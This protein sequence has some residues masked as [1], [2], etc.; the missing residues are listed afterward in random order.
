MWESGVGRPPWVLSSPFPP[1]HR[2]LPVVGGSSA[3]GKRAA[4]PRG[5]SSDMSTRGGGHLEKGR[6]RSR[7]RRRRRRSNR[8]HP[9]E[10]RV[11]EAGGSIPVLGRTNGMVAVG[12]WAARYEI[13][14][15][16]SA[17]CSSAELV[18]AIHKGEEGTEDILYEGRLLNFPPVERKSSRSERGSTGESRQSAAERDGKEPLL[19]SDEEDKKSE[20]VSAK[21]LEMEP[22]APG[23]AAIPPWA[24][25][26]KSNLPIPPSHHTGEVGDSSLKFAKPANPPVAKPPEV[27]LEKDLAEVQVKPKTE[28]MGS[29]SKKARPPS[30][31]SKIKSLGNLEVVELS[32]ERVKPKTIRDREAQDLKRYHEKSLEIFRALR[33]MGISMDLLDLVVGASDGKVNEERF[34]LHTAPNRASTGLRYA[35]LIYGEPSLLGKP[36]REACERESDT[37]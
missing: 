14:N 31:S 19:E 2:S 1:S 8:D 35:R 29:F 33:I 11:A 20:S 34:S 23:Q 36:R 22:T 26:G 24:K 6:D 12:A 5:V 18:R 27:K 17:G 28:E 9:P 37:F 16:L 32:R 13:A 7:S 25:G 3:W 4:T 10:Q 21:L 15:L 30:A